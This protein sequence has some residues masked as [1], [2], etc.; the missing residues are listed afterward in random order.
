MKLTILDGPNHGTMT[1]L[2]GDM[3]VAAHK[4]LGRTPF[5]HYRESFDVVYEGETSSKKRV[6]LFVIRRLRKGIYQSRPDWPREQVW[7][8]Q[9]SIV[10]IDGKRLRQHP[11]LRGWY[12]TIHRVGEA[13]LTFKRQRPPRRGVG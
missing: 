5:E 1:S 12:S 2:F 13:T 8:L 4:Q 7:R 10:A 11:I 9:A 6:V 3:Q